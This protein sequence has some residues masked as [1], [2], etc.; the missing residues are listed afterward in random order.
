MRFAHSCDRTLRPEARNLPGLETHRQ[1]DGKEHHASSLE[2]GRSRVCLLYWPE[3][4]HDYLWCYS[5]GDHF[6]SGTLEL[7]EEAGVLTQE[8]YYHLWWHGF[9]LAFICSRL[10]VNYSLYLVSID[11][12]LFNPRANRS[13]PN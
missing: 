2:A 6:G 12:L 13:P 5:L 4:Y 7:D 10:M 8:H 1:V 3:G 11:H 9:Y